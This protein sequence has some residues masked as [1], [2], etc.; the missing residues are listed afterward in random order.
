MANVFGLGNLMLSFLSDL[1]MWCLSP[2][3]SRPSVWHQRNRW[4]ALLFETDLND[5]EV[6]KREHIYCERFKRNIRS[7]P[8]LKILFNLNVVECICYLL[9][10]SSTCV[11]TRIS[12]GPRSPAVLHWWGWARVQ[13]VHAYQWVIFRTNGQWTHLIPRTIPSLCQPRSMW[14]PPPWNSSGKIRSA[15]SWTGKAWIQASSIKIQHVD[16]LRV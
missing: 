15:G 5:Q 14:S 7:R 12:S 1:T 2:V 13:I 16:L 10:I 9:I 11:E 4:S 8:F 3:L 6:C